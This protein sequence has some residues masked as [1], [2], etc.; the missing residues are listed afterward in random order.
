MEDVA[1]RRDKGDTLGPREKV[2]DLA[3]ALSDVRTRELAKILSK[4][5][6]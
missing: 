2:R 5:P 1:L 6:K 3:G 4:V